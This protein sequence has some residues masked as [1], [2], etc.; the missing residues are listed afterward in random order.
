MSTE[1]N[2]TEILLHL[3]YNYV[4]VKNHVLVHTFYQSCC[5]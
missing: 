3:N 2:R 5:L 4:V 1:Q